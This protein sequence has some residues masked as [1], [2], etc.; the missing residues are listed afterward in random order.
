MS[1][2]KIYHTVED[3]NNPDVILD[4]APFFCKSKIAWLGKGYYFWDSYIQNAHWWG[5]SRKF[6]KG[7]VICE[8]ICDF[9]IEKC[10]DLYDCPDHIE[11][12]IMTFNHMKSQGL[13]NR[14]TTVPRVLNYL[15][16]DIKVFKFEACRAYGILSKN[17][18]SKFSFT[19]KF[20][21]GDE[22]FLELRAPVQICFYKK[23]GLNMRNF[24]IIHPSTYCKDDF[25]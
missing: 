22:P 2:R 8:A 9:S 4:R 14:Y 17:E 21:I 6:E 20:N 18:K 7:Y 25:A 11:Q 10:F 15:K 1:Q 23:D 12:F 16:Y 3:R 24:K 13:A 19:M 5:T